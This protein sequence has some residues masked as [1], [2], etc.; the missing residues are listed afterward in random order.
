MEKETGG[1][2]AAQ[3]KAGG[4]SPLVISR[5]NCIWVAENPPDRTEMWDLHNYGVRVREGQV[6]AFQPSETPVLA[7]SGARSG[8]NWSARTT[9]RVMQ[10]ER[11]V[12]ERLWIFR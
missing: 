2:L 3:T 8:I 4:V 5:R 1:Q 6:A 11:R 9:H 7:E 10:P 12:L